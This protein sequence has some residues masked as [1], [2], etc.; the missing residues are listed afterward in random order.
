MD[1]QLRANGNDWLIKVFSD[2]A[3]AVRINP[4]SLFVWKVETHNSP[5]AIDPYGG[6]IT[7]ILGNNRDPLATGIGGARL[8]FNTNV[9]CFGNPEFNGTL[10]SNQLHPRR[11]FEGVR[12]GI[13][14]G[15][16]KSGVP[17]V[18][19]AI[20]FDDR[21]AGKPLV[22]CGTGAVM[23]MQLAGLDSWE[24]KIDAQDRIIM[25]GGRVGK[26]GIHG[27]TFSS[28]E[29]DET[30]PAT[31]VQIG[32]PITQKL[33]M[34]FLVLAT[35]RGLIK[36]STDNGAGGL[37]S[38]IGE[39]ATISGG[40][41]VE[42]EKVPLKYPGLRPWEIFVS[43]S[44]E[45]F[46]LAVE[47]AKMD[48]L[49]S[50]GREMEVELTDIGY[51][52]ADGYLDVRFDGDSVARLNMEFLHNG[53]PR[54]VLEAEW[55][56]PQAAEPT[57]PATSDYTDVLTRLLG[58]LNICSRESVIRQYDHE[59]KGRTIIKPL[60]GATGQ[61][62]QDAAVV[63]FNFESWE[64]V[65]VS[66][67]ILPRFGDLDAYHMSA[68]AFDEAVRQIV[69]VGGKLP[70]LSYGDGNFWSVNDN[71]C[72]PDS[73]YDAT[74]NP[75]GKLKL[76]KLVRMCEALRDATA[77]YCI[78]LTSGKD[79]MK[80]DFK[81]DGV[82]ISVPPTVLYSMT[83]KIEDVRHTITSDFKQADD[84]IY[85][86]GE[87]YDELGGS[88]FYQLFGE[89]GANVPEVRFDKAK[90]LYTL[91]GQAND[92]HLI[93]SCHDLSDGG[94]AVALAEATFGHGYGAT[95]DLPEGLPVHVQ[96]FSESHS[97]F[98]AT[99][100]PEDVVAFEQHFGTRATRLGV[101][102]LDSHL[103]VRHAGSPLL[104]PARPCCATSGPTAR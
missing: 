67:G 69:A 78:P 14:D 88:E 37:S 3:G 33:A 9:L 98:V 91:M 90:E 56:K 16:N 40:A 30:S 77:A 95:V 39:L 24:K 81:A 53:V 8:L 48:E 38:S 101:V 25:A 86:L 85:L 17:T 10:L 35:R 76:A 22:Y 2:N 18:N 71:F 73:V 72:V 64:G 36:C 47:P 104:R 6:A 83:A 49:L 20:V 41:V 70:N 87:T 102:T 96:L 21:Y 50:L 92:Q 75:D 63:R 43:E 74:T 15:G 65:A 55:S 93:Q 68:G 82:K 28:I 31:A 19:G 26:D 7:G 45:R 57:L 5:S 103:T 84:V 27:A 61:A 29:L 32:S 23:P 11:I 80:N 59:V 52:T 13:E 1:R 4:E 97:R 100:A 34:D 94:L 46:S 99:V 60:M 42:L 51:F 58:S 62:P 89:L 12:K 44:Q 66:N 79:S 54:K